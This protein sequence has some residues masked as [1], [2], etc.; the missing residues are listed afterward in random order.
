M[1]KEYSKK[2]FLRDAALISTMLATG[3]LAKSVVE[4]QPNELS[5]TGESEDGLVHIQLSPSENLRDEDLIHRSI[6]VPES[7]P[8]QG[9]DDRIGF[10]FRL[11]QTPS[12]INLRGEDV[13]EGEIFTRDIVAEILS[14]ENPRALYVEAFDKKVWTQ[15]SDFTQTRTSVSKIAN[16][17]LGA[18]PAAIR[19]D[20]QHKEKEISHV[21]E[22][23][24]EQ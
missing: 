10:N 12:Q 9:V 18:L 7:W 24:P 4:R 21:I 1:S 17:N 8:K 20:I 19:V 14:S 6:S 3:M 13:Y 5:E 2:R 15:S 23:K 16:L 11:E 22:F